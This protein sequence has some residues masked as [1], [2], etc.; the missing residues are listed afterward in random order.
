MGKN[1]LEAFSAGVIAIMV[2]ELKVPRRADF[3]V[4]LPLWPVFMSYVLSFFYVGTYWN[5]L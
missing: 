3:R 1:R 5:K 2:V 4:L